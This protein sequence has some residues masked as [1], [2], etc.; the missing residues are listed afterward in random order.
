MIT[1]A[2]QKLI[3]S[4]KVKKYRKKHAAFV[5]EGSKSVLE[6]LRSS[7]TV[8]KVY[9]LPEWAEAHAVELRKQGIEVSL[10]KQRE[11]QGASFLSTAD[12]VIAIA[13]LPEE[14]LLES[15]ITKG[16]TLV[17]DGVRDPGNLGTIIRTADWFGIR[18]IV[19][20]EDCVDAY[21]PKVVRATMGSLFRSN[22]CY[23]ELADLFA[24]FKEVPVCAAVLNGHNAFEFKFPKPAFLVIGNESNGVQAATKAHLTHAV[25]IPRIGK[26]ES[27]NAAVAAGLLCA[28]AMK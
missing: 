27:L 11:L 10:A 16:L 15:H 17:L 7:L 14:N 12:Q 13:R 20:S 8:L 21:N 26:A 9:A 18:H 25:T 22:L 28:L 1:K 19:C 24:R 4:L 23:L 3:Q 5:V 2:K 6:L